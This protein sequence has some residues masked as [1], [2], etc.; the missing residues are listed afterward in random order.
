MKPIIR[1][2]ALTLLLGTTSEFA[3]AD[4]ITFGGSI[5]QGAGGQASGNLNNVAIGDSFTGTLNIGGA[6]TAPGTYSLTGS[7]LVFSVPSRSAT[8]TFTISG[9]VT[10]SQ[11]S[12]VDTF[13]MFACN[14]ACPGSTD[15]FSVNFTIPAS[16]LN[17]QNV[18]AS[19][20]TGLQGIDLSG[21]S[22]LFDILGNVTTYSYTA[23]PIPTS[24]LLLV[25]GL[26]GLLLLRHRTLRLPAIVSRFPT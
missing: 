4:M 25:S 24:G 8:E 10:I 2:I 9:N 14:P 1:G 26:I 19:N 16:G 20:V 5:T 12:G 13:S 17:L 23:V 11:A 15:T 3:M 21:N 18:T 7:N 22:G 6:I